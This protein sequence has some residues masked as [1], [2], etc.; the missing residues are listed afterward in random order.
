VIIVAGTVAIEAGRRDAAV[1]IAR[2]MATATATEPGCLRYRFY[3][4]L[5]DPN[6]FFV[7]EEWESEEALARHFQT[8][9]MRAFQAELPTLV[10]G[11]PD[12]RRYAVT[13][14]SAMT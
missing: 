3:A 9:H 1:R 11:A 10:A 13:A 14:V 6:T 4:D 5:D 12:I 7:Y 8:D 2:A